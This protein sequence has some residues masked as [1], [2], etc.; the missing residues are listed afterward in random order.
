MAEK[1]KNEESRLQIIVDGVSKLF[2][3]NKNLG[4]FLII[5][6]VL[7]ALQNFSYRNDYSSTHND[8]SATY[9]IGHAEL[10]WLAVF[11]IIFLIPF[12]LAMIAVYVFIHGMISY[13]ALKSID[14]KTPGISEAFTATKGKFWT[15]L[16]VGIIVFFKVVGGLILFIVPGIRAASRYYVTPF[17]VFDQ[18]LSAGETVKYAKELTKDRLMT[19]FLTMV[20]AA[21]L[22]PVGY[23]IQYGG[24]VGM[25]PW[26]KKKAKAQK[27]LS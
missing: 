23:L 3:T 1:S 10:A 20:G 18:N 12:V 14:G 15:L 24:M 4:W 17:V 25:Y 27:S 16:G 5:I 19:P 11:F 21:I 7:S 8:I 22:S 2:N 26:L 6:S 9:N 13:A